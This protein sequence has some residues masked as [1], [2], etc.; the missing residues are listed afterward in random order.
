[1]SQFKLTAPERPQTNKRACQLHAHSIFLILHPYPICASMTILFS[2]STKSLFLT[3]VVRAIKFA[4]GGGC[5]AFDFF[6]GL[7][8]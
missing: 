4:I 5:G 2:R 6:D 1:M 3:G 7:G 8:C